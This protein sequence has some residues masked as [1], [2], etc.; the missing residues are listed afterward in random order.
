MG[1]RLCA[2]AEAGK[3][4]VRKDLLDRFGL[5]RKFRVAQVRPMNFKGFFER[6]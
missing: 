2:S 1:A 6:H 4:L 5:Q 3:I